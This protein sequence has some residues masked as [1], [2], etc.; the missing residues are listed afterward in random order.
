MNTEKSVC[1]GQG[2]EETETGLPD[3]IFAVFCFHI[4]TGKNTLEYKTQKLLEKVVWI[5]KNCTT[6]IPS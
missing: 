2:S 4:S 1:L 6:A 5:R 3:N